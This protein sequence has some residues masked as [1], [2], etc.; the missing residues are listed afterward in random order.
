MKEWKFNMGATLIEEMNYRYNNPT[1][2][3]APDEKVVT[4][5]L[6]RER[7]RHVIEQFSLWASM[8]RENVNDKLVSMVNTNTK[9]Q[10]LTK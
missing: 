2:A 6:S 1:I 8:S 9:E 3:L 5:F 4:A 10:S 7:E